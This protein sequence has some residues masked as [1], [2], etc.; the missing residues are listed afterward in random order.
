MTPEER[1]V[2]CYVFL[3]TIVN[4]GTGVHPADAANVAK[5]RAC[6]AIDTLRERK[7]VDDACAALSMRVIDTVSTGI[8]VN[9]RS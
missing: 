8:V 6:A 4:A 3:Q 7:M 9:L 2:W 5:G 1:H